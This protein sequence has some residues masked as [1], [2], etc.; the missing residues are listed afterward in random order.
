M[1]SEARSTKADRM[2]A[3][4]EEARRKASADARR[5]S[6][7]G[8][9]AGVL[10]VLLAGIAVL[11]LLNR[12]DAA[13]SGA[14]SAGEANAI[15]TLGTADYHSL[16]ISPADP[17]TVFFG[18]HGGVKKSTDGGRTWE[19]LAISQDAMGMAIAPTDPSL[20]YIAGHDVFARSTD[21]GQT[22]QTLRPTLPGTDIHGFA[23]SPSDPEH[24]YAFVAE[25]GGVYESRDGGQSWEPLPG[26]A[27]QGIM[28]L[29]VVAGEPETILAG[30]MRQGVMRSRDGGKTWRSAGGTLPGGAT[31]FATS[32]AQPGLA[33]AG[34]ADGV[35]RSDDSGASWQPVGPRGVRVMAVATSPKDPRV[36]QA[37]DAEGRV[38]RSGDGGAS[39]DGGQ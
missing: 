4:R 9:A 11:A 19:D 27:P 23:M 16:A 38:Y 5:R 14:A 18:H 25:T 12:P 24:L 2:A 34:T 6:L 39:W 33:Y 36:I 22:W 31:A 7:V 17:E 26:E 29:A 13:T 1:R 10:G 28:G 37:V 20:L 35:Y 32:P 15:S 8:V 21:G 30:T 3:R